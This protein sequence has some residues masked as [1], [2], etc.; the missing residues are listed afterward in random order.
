M[1]E[2]PCPITIEPAPAN[3]LLFHLAKDAVVVIVAAGARSPVLFVIIHNA[4]VAPASLIHLDIVHDPA[5][6]TAREALG[7]PAWEAVEEARAR[8]SLGK[9]A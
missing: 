3:A 9:V 5:P 2:R 6:F 4:V 1:Q 7:R 8:Q